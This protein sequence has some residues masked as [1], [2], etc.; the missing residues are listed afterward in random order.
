MVPG[1]RFVGGIAVHLR[2]AGEACQ[3][4]GNLGGAASVGEHVGD[5]RRRRTSPGAIVRRMRPKLAGP[6][7]ATITG[8][9]V[10]LQKIRGDA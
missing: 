10:S 7:P 3:L 4:R 1:K 8:I 9:G 6:G 5:R 2:D